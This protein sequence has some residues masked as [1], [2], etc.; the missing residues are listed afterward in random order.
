M[1]MSPAYTPSY[2]ITDFCQLM[3]QPI[4]LELPFISTAISVAKDETVP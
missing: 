1:I 4:P 3:Y 2:S